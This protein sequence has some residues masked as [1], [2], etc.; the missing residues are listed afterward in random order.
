MRH[1]RQ[2]NGKRPMCT[3]VTRFRWVLAN[4]LALL[5]LSF[6]WPASLLAGGND[7]SAM[8]DLLERYQ[9]TVVEIADLD[10]EV[11][12]FLSVGTVVADFD[13]DGYGDVALLSKDSTTRI[14]KLDIF[15]CK[16]T[17]ELSAQFDL[18]SFDGFQFIKVV[19]PGNL[20][21]SAGG[22]SENHADARRLKH[23]AVAAISYGKSEVVFYYN[24][25]A[26]RFDSITT[27]D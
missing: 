18:G 16:D 6:A 11:Q 3:A 8:R 14:L 20:I 27:A 9:G 10:V 12:K 7:S 24:E 19:K 1:M 17:C 2:V 15:L 13:G 21:Q 5:G 22:F 25:E 23:H 4:C 26:R